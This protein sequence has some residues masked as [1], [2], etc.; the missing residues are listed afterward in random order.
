MT[1]RTKEAFTMIELVMVIV[2]IGIL[3]SMAIPRFAATRDDATISKAKSTVGAIRSAIAAE[4][5]KRILRGDFSAFS[6]LGGSTGYDKTLFDY[7]DG[8]STQSRILEYG[9]KSC[10]NGSLS[11]CWIKSS[12]K[13]YVFKMPITGHA[14]TFTFDLKSRFDCDADSHTRECKLLTQ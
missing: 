9:V 12:N 6:S 8:D 4:R 10:K 11:G 5:Q 3:A 13:S 2:V 14:I 1:Q 7:F